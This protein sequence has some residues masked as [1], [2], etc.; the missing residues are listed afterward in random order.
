MRI[1]SFL[2]FGF[3]ISCNNN[4][5]TSDSL[6]NTSEKNN[7]ETTTQ[8]PENI[9]SKIE[10]DPAF[11]VSKDTVSKHGPKNIT[12]NIL[13]D[14]KGILWFATWEGIIRNDG[15]DYTNLTLKEGLRQYHIQTIF[16]DSKGNLWF[17]TIGGG[18]FFYDGQNFSYYTKNDGLAGDKVFCFLED[19]SGRIWIGTNEGL[20]CY[21]GNS[22]FN[23]NKKLGLNDD[24]I[25]TIA[26][27]NTGKILIGTNNGICSCS[28]R[29]L[30]GKEKILNFPIDENHSFHT[31]RSIIND[32]NGK[33]L[34]A[35][36]EGLFQY[37]PTVYES[38][39]GLLELI[40]PK[41]FMNI[42]EDKAG[43]L[44][45]SGGKKNSNL[46]TLFKYDRKTLSEISSHI[47]VFGVC[48]DF[49]NNIWYGTERGAY[50]F[51]GQRGIQLAD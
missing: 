36:Q 19:K 13:I 12:R 26:Q 38:E 16:E 5:N 49:Q 37:T 10:G 1:T 51:D 24:F 33:I 28:E 42:F 30:M 48:E 20:S 25:Y 6:V 43:N 3:L 15:K 7:H 29:I 2:F 45:L 17:G 22:F 31:V 11:V 44:W 4:Q 21:F 8:T 32:K 50:K 40:Y 46:M 35:S 14:K 18:V 9:K 27:E 39:R 34:I 41:I 47:Q 23:L